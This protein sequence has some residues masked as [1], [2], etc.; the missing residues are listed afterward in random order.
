VLKQE[1]LPQAPNSLPLRW[2]ARL[3]ALVWWLALTL[4]LLLALYAGLGR[5][6]TAD[7][8]QYRDTVQAQLS[9][10]LGY[11]VGIGELS[12]RWYWLNPEFSAQDV[13]VAETGRDEP[14]AYL[15]HLRMRVDFLASVL[16]M[17]L[18][19][20]KFE[21]DG[22]DLALRQKA[23]GQVVLAGSGLEISDNSLQR[24]VGLAE[25]W[26]SKPFVRITRIQLA[27]TD[28]SGNLRQ[29]DIPQLDLLYQRGLFRA[30]GR[31]MQAGTNQQLASFRLVGRRFLRGQFTGQLYADVA[32]GRLFDGL[33]DDYRWRDMRVEGFDVGGQAWLSFRD[34]Q[35]EQVNGT[36][37]TPYLQLGTGAMSLAPLEDIRARFGWRRDNQRPGG[38]GEWH[39]RQ[40]QWR[41][42][43]DQV[44]PF[45]A[46]L[47]TMPNNSAEAGP[48]SVG[49][50]FMADALPLR[51]LRR[52][53]AALPLLPQQ[54]QEALDDYKPAGFLDAMRLD[55]PNA[56]P[57][58]FRLSA[59]LRDVKVNAHN[60]APAAS[61]VQGH[62]YVDRRG[63]YVDT[64]A[65]EQ[66]VEIEF[67]EL[68][69]ARWQFP[70]FKALVAW[71]IDGALIRIFSEGMHLGVGEQ[72]ELIGGF[73]LRLDQHGDDNLGL[74]VQIENGDAA[75]IAELVPEYALAPE[76]YTWLTTAIE[77]GRISSGAYYGHGQIGAGAPPG[78]FMSAMWY[79]FEEATLRYDPQW[80]AVTNAR[81]RV[82]VHNDSAVV[83]VEQA[84]SGGL[85][86]RASKVRL[87]TD[88]DS[89]L[90][91]VETAARVPV[92]AID[93]W[94]ENSPLGEFAGDGLSQVALTG[95]MDLQLAL[96]LPL[97][98]PRQFSVDALVAANDVG[99][100]HLPTGLEWAQIRGQARYRSE[101]GISGGPMQGVF[102]GQPVTI[103]L[104]SNERGRLTVTQ[105]GQLG[106]GALRQLAGV[107]A[108]ASYGI[109]GALTYSADLVLTAASPPELELYSDLRGLT[110]NWPGS[111]EKEA[112]ET[113]P[114]RLT[115]D[116]SIKDGVAFGVNW[117]NRGHGYVRKLN[118]GFDARVDYLQF[119]SS[120]LS[121]I[122]ISALNLDKQWTVRLDSNL[123]SGRI[124][125][126]HDDSELTVDLQHLNLPG[127][128]SQEPAPAAVA[129]LSD[130]RDS[131][132]A[133]DLRPQDW[134]SAN[135]RIAQL[136]LAGEP[137]GQWSFLLRPQAGGVNIG[138]IE[139]KLESLALAGEFNWLLPGQTHVSRFKGSVMGGQLAELGGLFGADI[140]LENLSTNIEL[141]LEWPGRPDQFGLKRLSGDISMT[142]EDG[143]ILQQNNSAQLF[144]VFNLL[145]TD[146]LWRRLQLDFSDLYERGVAFDALSGKAQITNGLLTLDPE[147][148]IVGPSGAF[149]LSGTT[150]MASES[151]D[152]RLVV[153]VPLTQ[154][155]PLA[156]LLMGA[157]APIGGALF[158]LD[159]ILG[160][161]LSKLTSAS[162][163]VSGTWS[164]PKTNLQGVFGAGD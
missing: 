43:G 147:L 95:S 37:R 85:A 84:S 155:L 73:D 112:T 122:N 78:S 150:D 83:S 136:A 157:G 69:S 162:Y 114:L 28:S 148:Q 164:E 9:K 26:L 41:W 124:E 105:S 133:A 58:D 20:E 34:G 59:R 1:S 32:S 63:G 68:F 137:L 97:N 13:T 77:A 35:L 158:V 103:G 55:I 120:R 54:A 113:A 141:A 131:G 143:V 156:A 81:G 134:P 100:Q 62:I 29:L 135:V 19:L 23:A 57:A 40:L 126:P 132:A 14:L 27:V 121:D 3:S 24:W 65:A 61:Y 144:R 38:S 36:L 119:G 10:Q 33:I 52:L 31:A 22:L 7:M 101:E 142:L 115:L 11:T 107:G 104:D 48:D 89:P 6:L 151:L 56:D 127:N 79:Q 46:Q 109:S 66:P 5:Q 91:R 125:I 64:Y 94:M 92:Q 67:P 72:T 149:K 53:V 17:R 118:T 70:R 102:E 146:T 153:V 130:I 140:P 71:Q 39:L 152:M 111:F 163:K 50:R 25:R 15:R 51:P 12:A 99:L 42:N 45:S 116:S 88:N 123:V 93:L 154:N 80:P 2:L 159:K 82:E 138:S 8:N 74:Q 106:V 160:D 76:L 4:L 60:G 108:D 86:L 47:T 87:T 145:N 139:G 21:A 30:S 129:N 44:S 18:V 75:M 49:V 96:R 117:E 110:L 128:D 90:I 16:R 98:Q 161:P